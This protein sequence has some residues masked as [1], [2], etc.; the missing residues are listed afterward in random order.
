MAKCSVDDCEARASGLGLCGK[1]YMRVRRN[2]STD[3]KGRQGENNGRWAGGKSSH[4]L[5]YIYFD[6]VSRCTTPTHKKYPDYGGRGI[7]VHP[8][9]VEDFWNFVRDVGPRP[10]ERK[11]SGG[12]AYW[13]LDRIDN[14]GD[15]EPG[16]VRW[17]TPEQQASNKRG[18]GDFES[19]R[20]PK[21]GRF[22]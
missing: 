20:D 9:W 1:H 11:T 18:Y 17:A 2:G 12:R 3:L 7:G 8:L 4:P 22:T 13:Q 15:Y 16:N 14:D 5:R 19:R 6:M 10:D 21:T